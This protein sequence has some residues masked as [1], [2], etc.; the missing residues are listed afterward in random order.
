MSAKEGKAPNL[1]KFA[2]IQLVPYR[3]RDLDCGSPRSPIKPLLEINQ[4]LDQELSVILQK[5]LKKLDRYMVGCPGDIDVMAN[6]TSKKKIEEQATH[7]LQKEIW[8]ARELNKEVWDV[9]A[10]QQSML[11]VKVARK[12]FSKRVKAY[13]LMGGKDIGFLETSESYQ[14]QMGELNKIKSNPLGILTKQYWDPFFQTGLDDLAADFFH[15]CDEDDEIPTQTSFKSVKD[16]PR[17]VEDLTLNSLRIEQLFAQEIQENQWNWEKLQNIRRLVQRARKD[18]LAAL[19]VHFQ[20]GGRDINFLMKSKGYQE[21]LQKLQNI[22]GAMM[23]GPSETTSTSSSCLDSA[24]GDTWMDS[25]TWGLNSLCWSNFL[26]GENI[27]SCFPIIR[28]L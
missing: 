1:H 25:H 12:D 9:P 28:N 15:R 14:K 3:A 19:C 17:F 6:M 13:I 24:H 16:T 27:F 5:E 7:T 11:S 4:I 26:L 23:L 10:I 18:F 21:E 22:K 2:L 20:A 8:L